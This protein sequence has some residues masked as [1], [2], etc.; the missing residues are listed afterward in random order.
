MS[1]H[2]EKV[3]WRRH[4]NQLISRPIPESEYPRIVRAMWDDGLVCIIE[5][6]GYQFYSGRYK[7]S[8]ATVREMWS[9]SRAQWSR[10]MDY[11]YRTD[12]FSDITQGDEENE[13]GISDGS[14]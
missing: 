4:F 5:P 8:A 12:P 10:F 14:S 13:E 9:L 6:N 7:V 2:G 3:K 11:I 1:E